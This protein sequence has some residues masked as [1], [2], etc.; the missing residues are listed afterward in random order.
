MAEFDGRIYLDLAD[1]EWRV[2]EV[3]PGGWRI[4]SSSDVPIRFIRKRGMLPLPRPVTG[5]RVDELRKFVN[6]PDEDGW[7][8]YSA[9]LVA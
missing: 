9:C 6:V 3:D 2:V 4:K 8:L 5:G 1:G 7:I